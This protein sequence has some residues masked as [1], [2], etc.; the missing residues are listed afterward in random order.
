MWRC[1]C[2]KRP[3]VSTA[4]WNGQHGDDDDSLN[5]GAVRICNAFCCAYDGLLLNGECLGCMGSESCCCL[6]GEFCCKTGVERLPCVCCGVRCVS[7]TVCWKQ[8]AQCCCCVSAVA[9]PCD[10]EV[11]CMVG[12]FGLICYPTFACFSS[13]GAIMAGAGGKDNALLP[14]E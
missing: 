7:P 14:A 8:Q 5:N 9:V 13:L 1:G 11:P 12:M 3:E 4:G 2:G 10:E 6:E